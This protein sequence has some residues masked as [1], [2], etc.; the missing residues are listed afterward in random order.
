MSHDDQAY[1]SRRAEL[2][3]DQARR[4]AN[5]RAGA[6]HRELARAYLDRT[7][8]FATDESTDCLGA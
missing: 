8:S 4:A 1:Y 6:V 3:L 5:P 7:A 2:E